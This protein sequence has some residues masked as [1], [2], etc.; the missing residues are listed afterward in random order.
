MGSAF[1]PV[2]TNNTHPQ[3]ALW[4]D[5]EGLF[6]SSDR[7]GGF[8]ELDIWFISMDQQAYNLGSAINTLGNEVTPFYHSL[9]KKLYLKS[10]LFLFKKD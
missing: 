5:K 4:E 10:M 3:W 6:I 9:E 7:E 2:Q 8:G 1:N